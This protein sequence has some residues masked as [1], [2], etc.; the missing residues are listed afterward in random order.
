MT[1]PKKWQENLKNLMTTTILTKCKPWRNCFFENF[2][3]YFQWLWILPLALLECSYLLF[4]PKIF[5][6]KIQLGG[7][8]YIPRWIRCRRLFLDIMNWEAL[9]RSGCL[10]NTYRFSMNSNSNE[11]KCHM[12][13]FISIIMIL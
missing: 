12:D 13:D 5:Y 2:K 1:S 8:Y 3:Y 4:H 6:R 10:K 11:F 9:L 7:M